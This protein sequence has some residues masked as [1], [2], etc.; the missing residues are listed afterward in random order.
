M[1]LR[2][3]TKVLKT[4]AECSFRLAVTAFNT[5]EEDD[6]RATQ[7]LLTTQHAFEMLL[8]AALTQKSLTVKA[9]NVFDPK[10]GRSIGFEK[11]I[12][13]GR[14]H[15]PLGEYDANTLRAI[16]ALR[17]VEQHWHGI[18]SEALLYNHMRAA[19]TIFDGILKRSFNERIADRLP[20]RVLPIST[21]PP[22][23]IQLLIDE[24]F[25]QV[26]KLLAP[27]R[28]GRAE[29]AARIRTL[30]ALQAHTSGEVV[31]SEQDVAHVAKKVRDGSPRSEIFPDLSLLDMNVEGEGLS[32]ELH[33][34][35]SGKGAPVKYVTEGEA[36]VGIEMRDLMA[37]YY[38]TPTQ[39][40]QKLGMSGQWE[41]LKA[42]RWHCGIDDE[43]DDEYHHVWKRQSI[44]IHGYSDRAYRKMKETLDSPGFDLTQIVREYRQARN[45]GHE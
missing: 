25:T 38:L 43:V 22:R 40:S 9:I 33:F 24:E 15:V 6:G 3:D 41:K 12:N 42:L 19:V 17:D 2:A 27:H 11:C 28:K 23:D 29:A 39:L 32:L 34:S 36:A 5:L 10:D 31:I 35:R 21:E 26:Q 18:V 13:L 1:R 4:K 45:A 44:T 30:L 20:A 37:K 16:D 14:E 8:K 7:V